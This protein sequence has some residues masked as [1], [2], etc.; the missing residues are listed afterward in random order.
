[1]HNKYMFVFE[2]T[3]KDKVFTRKNRTFARILYNSLYHSD[4]NNA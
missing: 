1:M 2:N 4:E 3:D